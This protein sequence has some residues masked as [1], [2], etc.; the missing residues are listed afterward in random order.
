MG[1]ASMASAA[2]SCVQRGVVTTNCTLDENYVGSVTIANSGITLDC[3]GFRIAGPNGPPVDAL[4]LANVRHVTVKNCLIQNG[5]TGINIDHSRYIELRHNR[6]RN[7]SGAGIKIANS[8]DVS[9]LDG[10]VS[11][12]LDDGMELDASFNIIVRDNTVKENNDEGIDLDHT[13]NVTVDNVT[14]EKNGLKTDKGGDGI[15]VTD[16]SYVTI[17]GCEFNENK[18]RGLDI[19]GGHVVTVQ[20]NTFH[21]NV[22]GAWRD[23]GGDTHRF[24]FNILQ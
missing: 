11:R 12:N 24:L 15:G 19:K 20:A 1:A 2:N 16:S 5:A 9:V 6:V 13:D 4:I 8:A 14:V 23:E 3:G 21:A 17:V 18:G 10:D 7:N 22:K